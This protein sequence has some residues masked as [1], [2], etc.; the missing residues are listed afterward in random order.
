[1]DPQDSYTRTVI[2]ALIERGTAE[3][4]SMPPSSRICRIQPACGF[5]NSPDYVYRLLTT[6][7]PH[8][9]R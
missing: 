4:P 5:A 2:A 9:P 7:L 8:Q 6:D 1:M 3:V